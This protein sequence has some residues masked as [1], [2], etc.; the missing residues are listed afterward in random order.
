MSPRAV[1]AEIKAEQTILELRAANTALLKRLAEAKVRT[2]ELVAAVYR[3]ARE[4][5][6]A[7]II[8][9]VRAPK[10][11]GRQKTGE[12]AVAV[13]SDWQMAKVTASYNSKVCEQRVGL[14]ADKVIELSE[15]Q[16]RHHPVREC[17]VYLLGDLVEG[18]LVFPG[19][20]YT[21]D[22]SLYEQVLTSGR[23]TLAH[24]VRRML[25]HF[26]RVRV[27]GVIGNHGAMGG[28]SR[29]E[30]SPES[31]AD[32]MMYETT[33]LVLKGEDG[34]LEPRLE[35]IANRRPG[36]RLWYAVDR[37]GTK[38][39][40]LFHGD[41]IKGGYADYPWYAFGKKILRWRNGGIPAEFHY[42]L[43]G[44]FHTV[45]RNLFG[46]VRHWASG[47]TESSNEYAAERI[48]NQ[49]DPSQW[50][51]FCHPERGVTAEYEVQLT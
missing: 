50:L 13:L 12:V 39:F 45:G 21:I 22:G 32:A 36:S 10:H 43:S 2:E 25:G 19:Q 1:S 24:F 7:L 23:R 40:L 15:I 8:P 35:W 9:P 30:Y 41:Q 28:R 42:A 47:S 26:E 27:V 29:R 51:L 44:H 46:R 16:R 37:I 11:D 17:R 18:E 49:G 5:A 34:S 31:N 3:A 48:G 6:D 20:A 33:R 14:Y 4:A 38:G